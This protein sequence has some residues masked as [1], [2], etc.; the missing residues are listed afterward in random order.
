MLNIIIVEDDPMVME[1]NRQYA[2]RIKGV[3]VLACLRDGRDALN[4]LGANKADLILM[5]L[6]MPEMT[7]L[8]LLRKLRTAGDQTDVIMVTADNALKDIKEAMSL[9]ILDY[10]IKPFEFARFKQAV[11]RCL[12]K[13]VLTGK[14][15]DGTETLTQEDIDLILQGDTGEPSRDEVIY[16][17]GI[18][19]STLDKLI[20]CLEESPGEDAD[21]EYL[22]SA[23]GLSKVT[24]RRYMNYLIENDKAESVIDYKTGGRPAIRYRKKN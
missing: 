12:A 6:Y 20:S 19:S 14:E 9:G 11:E 13:H 5:D 21:C 2:N 15:K 23:S 10:L 16:D 22:A 4:Y 3:K 24:V 8:E 17:K 18:Q 7:G 1:I